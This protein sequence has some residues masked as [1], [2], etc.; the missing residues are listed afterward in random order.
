MCCTGRVIPGPPRRACRRGARSGRGR[1]RA[2]RPGYSAST[3]S[4]A[5]IR[6]EKS[7]H[8]L[9]I[10]KLE[11]NIARPEPKRV[12]HDLG[13]VGDQLGVDPVDERALAGE[14]DVDVRVLRRARVSASRHG[15]PAIGMPAWIS[16][17]V[18]S[19][20]SLDELQR[21]RRAG[22]GRPAA[23]TRS[24]SSG[25]CARFAL[26]VRVLRRGP[27]ALAKRNGL[28]LVPVQLQA[29]AAQQRAG[30]ELRLDR[31]DRVGREQV[32]GADD[33]VRPARALVLL[34]DPLDLLRASPPA[35]SWPARRPTG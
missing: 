23:R 22:S 27:G 28:V 18:R 33:R 31:L 3:P 26:N 24:P 6:L 11:P 7:V 16:T 10:G 17:N 13:H 35:A 14:L 32:R 19:G 8:R 29:G 1:L 4:H 25:S 2:P 30:L 21:R 5:S 15:S 9:S 34:L 12:E 20:W